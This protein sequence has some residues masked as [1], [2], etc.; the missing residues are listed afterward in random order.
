MSLFIIIFFLIY[1]GMHLYV[2]LKAKTAFA[3]GT[4]T[5]L[6]LAFFMLAMVFVPLIGRFFERLDLEI[7]ARLIS[8]TGYTWMGIIFLFFSISLC[9]DIY[10]LLVYLIGALFNKD[11]SAIVPTARIAFYIP[12]LLSVLI[13]TYGYFE[14]QNI[15]TEKVIIKTTKIPEEIGR[16]RIV[17]ISDVHLGL[18]IKEKRL[19]R[20]LEEVK[21]AEPDILV[22]TGDLVDGQ[23]CSIRTLSDLFKEINPKY[24]K[25]AITG[26]HEFYAGLGYSLDF[27]KRAGFQILRGEGITVANI[28]NIAGIDD[29]AGKRYNL[30]NDISEKKLLSALPQDKFTLLLKH[31]PIVDKDSLGIFDLQLSGHAHKGQIFP[32]S[33]VTWLYYRHTI[34]AGHLRLVD[35]SY[36]YVSRG[37]GTWG[38]PI[39]FLSPPEITVIE[40]VH[41]NR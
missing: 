7:P 1:G 25:Y 2:F 16:L 20:I 18:I 21:K 6:S 12:L 39:R 36:L 3:L 26:N 9:V 34:H 8:Y 33:L 4:W 15:Q 28:I 30:Y 19:R 27:T 17:Q 31:R 10:R 24:G 14:A 22:S 35:D 5:C 11:L 40:L 38:P 32:F 29:P 41:N 23:I 37:A 13:A